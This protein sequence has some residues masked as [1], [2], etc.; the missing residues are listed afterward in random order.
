MHKE[1][2]KNVKTAFRPSVT[3]FNGKVAKWSVLSFLMRMQY[4]MHVYIYLKKQGV[5]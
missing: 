3:Y 2:C 4:K 5:S 1:E